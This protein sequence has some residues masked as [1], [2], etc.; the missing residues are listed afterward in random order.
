MQPQKSLVQDLKARFA[1]K[2]LHLVVKTEEEEEQE[3]IPQD[4]K[5]ILAQKLFH[6]RSANV[7]G[8]IEKK[9]RLI[10][11]EALVLIKEYYDMAG[12]YTKILS[13]NSDWSST[14]IL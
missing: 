2:H 10:K 9:Q 12:F 7:Q 5:L 8:D 6:L 14:R 13:R 1:C 3:A 4:L 11:D